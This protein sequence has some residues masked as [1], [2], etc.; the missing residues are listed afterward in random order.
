MYALKSL[1][2]ALIGK[3]GGKHEEEWQKERGI[4][5]IRKNSNKGHEKKWRKR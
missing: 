1:L 3:Y 5:G 2:S 4:L